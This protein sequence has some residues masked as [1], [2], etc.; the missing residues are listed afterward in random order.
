[1]HICKC[2]HYINMN[3]H[4]HI[5]ITYVCKMKRNTSDD[6]EVG[7]SISYKKYTYLKYVYECMNAVFINI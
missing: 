6:C 2:T 5:H 1:M 7:A 3:T 4:V